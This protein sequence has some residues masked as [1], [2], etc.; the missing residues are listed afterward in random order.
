MGRPKW[1]GTGGQKSRGKERDAMGNL[2]C[3]TRDQIP[4]YRQS[5]MYFYEW[6]SENIESIGKYTNTQSREET[7]EG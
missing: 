3:E 5:R 7:R 1:Y 2:H 4:K 6:P